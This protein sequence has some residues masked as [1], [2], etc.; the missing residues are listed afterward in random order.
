MLVAEPDAGAPSRD[1]APLPATP[2]TASGRT[3]PTVYYGWA[4]A[5]LSWLNQGLGY[6][7]WY[8]FSLFLVALTQEFG[9]D[10]GSTSAAFSVCILSG[11][12][13]GPLVG[14]LVDRL[15]PRLVIPIGALLTAAGL[16]ACAWVNQQ[17]EF[18]LAYG[19]VA[20]LG[21][22]SIGLVPNN[23]VISRWFVRRL[24]IAA[25]LAS[26]GVGVGIF[27]LVPQIQSLISA[28]GWRMTYLVMAGVVLVLV[29]PLN[30][31]FQRSSPRQL[32]L[33]PDGETASPDL[34]RQQVLHQSIVDPAWTA[35]TWTLN[36]AA[37]TGRFWL[38]FAGLG[39]ATFAQQL[40]IVHQVAFLID[41]GRPLA[42]AAWVAGLYGLFAVPAKIGLGAAC[43][44]FGR[45]IT[46]ALGTGAFIMAFPMLAFAAHSDS[47]APLVVYA[48]LLGI[49]LATIGPIAPGMVA[50]IFS[51]PSY[52][53][54][55][56]A[57]LIST[58]LGGALGAWFA[59]WI[60]DQ[61]GD[62]RTA[63]SAAILAAAV[64]I[65]C[66]WLAAPRKVRFSRR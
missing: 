46:F 33:E 38:L 48:L 32:G 58:G 9:W 24:G 4:I 29:L 28:S 55:F 50:D 2:Q 11:A 25:G 54:I 63:F 42:V 31:L 43:D 16:A 56:G 17:W 52:G 60:F 44:R 3:G 57:I 36:H 13:A 26:T 34:P 27:A 22:T 41:A 21:V 49:G 37:R 23:A 7:V 35:R 39:A 62:Y 20:G 40:L 47:L 51:G 59:G 61:T 30:L 45:E 6:T 15:G 12:L 14:L 10:R 64:A 65:V 53:L 66:C 18:F 8:S 1:L 5:G 19:L